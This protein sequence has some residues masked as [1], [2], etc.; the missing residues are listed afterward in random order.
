[1]SVLDNNFDS[2]DRTYESSARPQWLAN[3]SVDAYSDNSVFYS[4]WTRNEPPSWLG[5]VDL[6]DSSRGN[7]ARVAQEQPTDGGTGYG[8]SPE[9]PR[10]R[11]VN[12]DDVTPPYVPAEPPHVPTE[13]P[14]VP[15][16]TTG[17][18]EEMPY[19]PNRPHVEADHVNPGEPLPQEP[20][21]P[22][23]RKAASEA[24]QALAE[25]AR[26]LGLKDRPKP[27]VLGPGPIAKA[28][29]GYVPTPEGSG[30]GG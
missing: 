15:G 29:E 13:P 3:A 6:Y 2:F 24:A 20:A 7:V 12:V 21:Q 8:D 11:P 18:P 17:I 19:K 26:R 4:N 27:E 16:G 23:Q 5:G 22:T 9:I 30:R 25:V 28:I 14:H 10:K 1:M